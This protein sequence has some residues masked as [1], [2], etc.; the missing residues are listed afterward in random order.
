MRC[1]FDPEV[2]EC[3]AGDAPNCLTA[4]QV[5]AARAVYEPSMNRRT[6]QAL[7]P[8]LVPGSE[9]GWGLAPVGQL[10]EEPSSLARGFFGYVV[11]ADL[12]W[13]IVHSISIATRRLPTSA[14]AAVAAIASRL[15]IE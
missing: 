2:V 1:H 15:T 11:F 9:V 4:A 14:A 7:Y 10:L 13:T 12:K 6:Q 5:A 8:G 3:T